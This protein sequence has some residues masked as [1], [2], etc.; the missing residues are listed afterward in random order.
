VLSVE[1]LAGFP[2]IKQRLSFLNERFLVSAL[3]QANDLLIV[4]L[5][6]LHRIWKILNCPPKWQVVRESRMVSRASQLTFK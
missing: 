2:T 5:D 6:E 1:I 4:T 3:V